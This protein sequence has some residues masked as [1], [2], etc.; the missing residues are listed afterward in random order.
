[1]KKAIGMTLFHFRCS[2]NGQGESEQRTDKRNLATPEEK[3]ATKEL[4]RSGTRGGQW[5]ALS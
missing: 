3:R 2:D 4:W 1:M 5:I